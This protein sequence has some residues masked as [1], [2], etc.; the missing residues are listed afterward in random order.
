MY[1]FPKTALVRGKGPCWKHLKHLD[2]SVHSIETW[3]VVTHCTKHKHSF[4]FSRIP[5]QL[6]IYIY[7]KGIK[8]GYISIDIYIYINITFQVLNKSFDKCKLH[9]WHGIIFLKKWPRRLIHSW[10]AYK[11]PPCKKRMV[12]N[13][14]GAAV[15]RALSRASMTWN[16]WFH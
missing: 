15:T 12:E 14:L 16:S 5:I 8:K 9:V 3:N 10:P 13:G 2:S 7:Q 1:L 6:T 4:W 11:K